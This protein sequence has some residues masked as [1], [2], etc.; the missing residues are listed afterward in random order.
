MVW[1]GTLMMTRTDVNYRKINSNC[2][3][4]LPD[5]EFDV[6]FGSASTC[7]KEANDKTSKQLPSSSAM[8]PPKSHKL[9]CEH[10]RLNVVLRVSMR[11]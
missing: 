5:R 11:L 7:M 3:I 9:Y 6:N 8:L 1:F 10:N 4:G 2:E